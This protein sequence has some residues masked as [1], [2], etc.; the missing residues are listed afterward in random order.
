MTDLLTGADADEL[1][2]IAR[3]LRATAD[4]L[5][6]RADALT[7]H[8]RTVAWVGGVASQFG[9]RWSGTHRPRMRSTADY[10]RDAAVR[11]ERHAAEQR[12]ASRSAP[13]ADLVTPPPGGSDDGGSGDGGSDA[14]ARLEAFLDDLGLARDVAGLVVA[15]AHALESLGVVDDLLDLLTSDG[16]RQFLDGFDAVLDLRPVLVDVVTDFVD[17]PDLAFDERVVHALADAAVRFGIDEGMEVAAEWVAGAATTALLPGF[18]VVLAPIVGQ[19]AGAIAGEIADLVVDAIDE[20]T[21]FVDV[22]ADVV[23][24]AYRD[25]KADF[26]VLVDL[27]AAAADVA[28][29]AVELVGDVGSAVIEGTGDVIGGLAGAV[30][31]VFGA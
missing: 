29:D 8:L 5:D 31:D 18:G 23:V 13:V 2:R 16:V 7:L 24:D 10:V 17:H 12:H 11:L 14:V 30:G 26:G 27:A 20:T 6:R 21:D 3:S 4:D 15:G 9:S 1:E 25:V 19:V 22:V 28:G